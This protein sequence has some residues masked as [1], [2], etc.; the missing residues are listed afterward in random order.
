[1]FR[2]NFVLDHRQECILK[3]EEG[4]VVFFFFFSFSFF[5][6]IIFFFIIISITKIFLPDF[7]MAGHY[8]SGLKIHSLLQEGFPSQPM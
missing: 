3:K 5:I 4:L 7:C 8:Y 1:M 2:F 6:F